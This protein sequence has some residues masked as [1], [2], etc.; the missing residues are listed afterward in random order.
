MDSAL[1]VAARRVYEPPRIDTACSEPPVLCCAVVQFEVRGWYVF[2]VFRPDA[3]VTELTR[4]RTR[5]EDPSDAA[6]VSRCV[7]VPFMFLTSLPGSRRPAA[8]WPRRAWSG[9]R[10]RSAVATRFFPG[11]SRGVETRRCEP[12]RSASL[13]FVFVFANV[14]LSAPGR[15]FVVRCPGPRPRSSCS[16]RF[17]SLTILPS[18]K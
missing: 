13:P 4:P 17:A 2:A 18:S 3:L 10:R 12:S 1:G 16:E 15:C 7:P 14:P 9:S 5:P 8:P 6:A 11:I